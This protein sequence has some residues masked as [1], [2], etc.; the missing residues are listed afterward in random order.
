MAAAYQASLSFTVSQNSLKLMSIGSMM[1][2]NYL[3]LCCLLL[4]LP[5]GNS[6]SQMGWS[7][8]IHSNPLQSSISCSLKHLRSAYH[9]SVLSA[10]EYLDFPH[11][12]NRR[13]QW[14]PTPVLLPGKS[15]G[16]RSLVGWCIYKCVCLC[17]HVYAHLRKRL[18]QFTFY[19]QC[20]NVPFTW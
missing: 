5:L 18:S 12:E 7:A 14:H 11:M 3:S 15:H 17:V 2:S 20:K 16:W 8:K 10:F 6:K 13:R 1:P 9:A 19:Q 4:L